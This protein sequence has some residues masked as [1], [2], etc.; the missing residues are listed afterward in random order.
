MLAPTWVLA[1]ACGGDVTAA[2]ERDGATPEPDA[3]VG[4]SPIVPAL[5]C[6]DEAESLYGDP[7]PLPDGQGAIIRCVK[8]P[9]LSREELQ[10]RLDAMMNYEVVYEGEDAQ[11]GTQPYRILYTTERGNG[12]PGYSVASVYLPERPIAEKLPLIVMARGSRGQAP[13]CAPSVWTDGPIDNSD[14]RD[15]RMVNGDHEA[16]LL[17]LISSGFAVVVT[18]SAGYANFGAPNNPMSVY[19]D[20]SDMGK[21][22]VDSAHAMVELVPDATT[23]DI[24]FVGLSQGGHSALAALAQ[25][26]DYAPPGKILGTAV[27]TPLWF[28]QRAWGVTLTP[29]AES[30]GLVL[31]QS[32]ALPVSIW[33]HYTHAELYDG[34]GE[35]LSMFKPEVR[36]RILHFVNTTCWSETYEELGEG[37]LKAAKDYYLPSFIEA[38]GYGAQRRTCE[39]APD[40]ALCQKWLDRYRSDHPALT[41]AAAEVPV[42]IVYG[43]MDPVIA[44]QRAQCSVEKVRASGNP[45]DVCVDPDANHGG[46]A[47]RQSDYVRQW[48]ENKAFGR[49]IT[50]R[51]PMTSDPADACDPLLP[52]D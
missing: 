42:L 34:P 5:A 17:P 29:I 27:Y 28:A 30:A 37:G 3:A 22:L 45:L 13:S 36:E 48:I 2:G 35:G 38:V 40:E 31:N 19:A 8:D 43:L 18:D 1:A 25:S 26:A 7:G 4:E 14:N 11:S 50:L 49:E 12:Q 21:S 39:G 47:L 23:K 32:S 51:C 6:A 24:V 10:R 52:N 33:Y 44:P 16:V 9:F 15:G 20:A 41:G 46:S